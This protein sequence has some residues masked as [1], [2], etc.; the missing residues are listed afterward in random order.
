[1]GRKGGGMRRIYRC[2]REGKARN[3]MPHS[4]LYV[5]APREV[6]G[7]FAGFPRGEGEEVAVENTNKLI[8][9]YISKGTNIA[10]V[11]DNKVRAV[12]KKINQ[13]PREKLNFQTPAEVFFKLIT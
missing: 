9:Q 11:T 12:A 7:L 5:R 4:P 1:M 6:A 3:P 8:R 13:R 2:A 10:L